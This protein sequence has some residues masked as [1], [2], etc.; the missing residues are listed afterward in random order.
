MADIKVIY[1]NADGFDNEHSESADSVKMLS[2][3]T[4]TKELTDTKLGHLV[5]GADAADEHI[6]DARY[7]RENEHISTSAGAGDAGKPIITNSSG[8]VD[9]TFISLGTIQ[10]DTLAG[11]GD[12]DHT[13]YLLATGAR[14]L[15]GVQKYAS[16]VSISD[17][18]A[19]AH[20]K[21]VDDAIAAAELGNE[22]MESAQTRAITPP[23]SPATGQ[24][25]LI[26]ATLG[27][28]TGAFAG[29][30]DSVA[31]YDGSAWIF[32]VPATGT[33]IS[34]DTDP[35]KL[36]YFGG[37][38]WSEK[39]FE[40]TTASTGLTKV[41]MDIRLD[42]SAAG[43][44]LGF[45]SGV[46]S[47]NVT[48]ALELAAD[49][50]QVKADGIN[51]THIDWG[52]G[53][54]QVSAVDLPIADAGSLITATEVEGALQEIM[55]AVKQGFGFTAGGTINKGD[56]VYISA[57]DTVLPLS[58]ISSNAEVVGIAMF[59]AT[60][61]QSVRIKMIDTNLLGVLSGATAG[62]KYYWTGSALSATAPSVSGSNV[63]L[64][65]VA[66]NATD[67]KVSVM[68]VKKNA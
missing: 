42:S 14:D 16:L 28:A 59:A 39:F 31:Q 38:A 34:V 5:D 7:F 13:Q 45:A 50:V 30:E 51:D 44:G 68:H 35:T 64:A 15:S 29:H 66:K 46:L 1:K 40:S 10:H 37:S 52:T 48:G 25:V 22:W 9:A 53:T 20:K 12:D 17:D 36:Y 58:T 56:L 24:R 4:A 23:G 49:T 8:L 27:T 47:V 63:W 32:T 54:N 18:K 11:L 41:G 57:N 6:H 21:Y 55:A 33:F 3:K 62:A 26:D 65:G 2:F 67:L 61:G 19:L 60:V 43:D